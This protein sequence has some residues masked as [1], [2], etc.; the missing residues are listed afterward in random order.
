MSTEQATLDD[1]SESTTQRH[2]IMEGA[3]YSKPSSED[4][5]ERD[6]FSGVCLTC[7]ENAGREQAEVDTGVAR[8]FGDNDNNVPC[9]S[10]CRVAP[11]GREY[12]EDSRAIKGYQAGVGCWKG[13]VAP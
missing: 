7:V 10:E 13:E 3:L 4:T 12:H 5:F 2:L 9:C 6:Q 1:I 11:N 8:V